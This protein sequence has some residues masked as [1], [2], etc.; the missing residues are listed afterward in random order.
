M[1]PKNSEVRF[2]RIIVRISSLSL[3]LLLLGSG[4]Q[5]DIRLSLHE[6]YTQEEASRYCRELGNGWR[7]MEIAELFALPSGTSF[8]ENFSYW[9]ANQ[10]PS[11]KTVIGSGSEGDGG[12]IATVGYA[13]YPKERNITLSPPNKRIA[14]ACTDA[15]R[16]VRKRDYALT[17]EGTLDRESG[18]LWHS[19]DATDKRAKYTFAAAEAMCENLTLHGRN[20]RLPTLEELYGIVDYARFRPTVDMQYFGPMMHRYYWSSDELNANEAY[21]VGFKLGSVATAAKK[22]EAYARCV[23]E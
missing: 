21:V 11:D 1:P 20:W 4:A 9:S 15:P 6:A 19:L 3:L 8:G 18:L 16:P 2:W 10:G 14:A 5:A 17:P 22:E 13:Y 7:Q 12:I 23:S